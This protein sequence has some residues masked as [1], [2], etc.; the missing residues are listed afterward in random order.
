MREVIRALYYSLTILVILHE[1][2][3][4]FKVSLTEKIP[5]LWPPRLGN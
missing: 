4:N 3:E 5:Q 2:V 1:S